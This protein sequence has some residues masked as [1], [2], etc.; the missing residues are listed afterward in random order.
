MS[1]SHY[2][3]ARAKLRTLLSDPYFI[4]FEIVL[5]IGAFLRFYR[6]PEFMTFLGDQGRDAII[7]KRIL[8]GEHFPAIGPPTSYGQVYLG[9]FYY[10]FIAPWL[11][12]FRFQPAG[13][14]IGVAFFSVLYLIANYFAVK[15]IFD[16]KVALLST[17]LITFSITMISSSRFSWNPNLLSFAT[18]L[19]IYCFIKAI[20]TDKVIFYILSGIFLSIAIQLHYVSLFLIPG[21]SM[22]LL[23]HLY[24]KQKSRNQLRLAYAFFLASFIVFSSPLIIFDL[25]HQ[26]LNTHNFITLLTQSTGQHTNKIATFFASFHDLNMFALN[27]NV[28]F[29]LTTIILFGLLLYAYIESNK[30]TISKLMLFLFI[31]NLIAFSL[32]YSGPRFPHYFGTLYPLY[33]I[34]LA[35]IITIVTKKL[36]KK[37]SL[38]VISCAIVI[39]I[40]TNARGYYFINGVAS[41]QVIQAQ[42]SAKAIYQNVSSNTY[43]LTSLPERYSDSTYRYFLELSGKRPVEKDSIERTS[44]LFVVCD[45]PCKP[46]GDPQYDIAL[47][48]PT[49]VE[50]KFSTNGVIIYKLKNTP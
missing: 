47:F 16:K 29:F 50:K 48:A 43:R 34:L 40:A 21:I 18:L 19:A 31:C 25:R 9:P 6:I 12:L 11:F 49:R 10:Y 4:I 2:R 32:L 30:Q 45:K 23:W 3:T 5:C 41:N 39:F 33:Y 35:T 14:A 22:V 17:I 28:P 20:K 15:D 13:L 1:T 37:L 44:E 46:I 7:I 36:N 26:F 27:T 24:K 42:T 38:F 8:T